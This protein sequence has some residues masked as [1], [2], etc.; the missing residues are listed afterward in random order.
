MNKFGRVV[1]SAVLTSVMIV[2]PVMAAPTI[3]ELEQEKKAAENEVSSLQEQLTE[4]VG[5][6][7]QL[8]DDISVKGEEI[9]QAEEDLAEAEELER[10]Q[11][12]DMKLR[13]QFMYEQG[14]GSVIETIMSA[15]SFTDLVNKAEYVSSVHSYD[16][17]K[18]D[19]YIATKQQI[20]EL[21]AALEEEHAS[22]Q[23]MQADFE[24]EK[25]LL[26]A[27]IESK[28]SEIADLGEQ[29]Q[30][31]LIAATKKK[32]EEEAAAAAAAQQSVGTASTESAG[33]DASA[34]GNSSGGSGSG[35]PAPSYNGAAGGSSVSRAYGAL[36][37][38]YVSGAT[39]PNA[40]DCSGF[41]SY[42]LTGS[43]GRIGTSGSFGSLPRVD[44][45]QPGD[46]V[47]YA[48]HVGIYVGGGQ[49]IHAS[50][51]GT[52]V[53]Q[54]SIESSVSSNGPYWFTRY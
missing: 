18:L 53:I 5:K 15:E 54:S 48:G 46:I 24:A 42:C 20:E 35:K 34:G 14:D 9:L 29:L 51:E 45:P 39:G 47:C 11:Y 25:E 2:A 23:A 16:R 12:G 52:G 41:V 44:D 1:L 13:I 30:A 26:N 40:F 36:G 33:G 6:I 38:S 7:S 10:T 27:T 22:M 43:Y 28:Q 37:A 50:T 32:Q 31:A 8:E 4:I 49:M 3:D 19:E 17:K 21:K